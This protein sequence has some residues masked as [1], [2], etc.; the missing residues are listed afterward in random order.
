MTFV[1]RYQQETTWY[2]KATIMELFHLAMT[3]R[4]KSWTIAMTADSFNVSI[5]LVSENLKLAGALHLNPT[6][7]MTLSTRQEAL[8]RINGRRYARFRDNQE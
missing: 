7:Y 3:T 2:G 8:D 6:V 1:E 4:D 5:G